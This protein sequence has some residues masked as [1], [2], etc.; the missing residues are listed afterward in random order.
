MAISIAEANRGTLISLIKN[1]DAVLGL[2]VLGIVIV[3][4]IP[5]PPFIMDILLSFSITFSIVIILISMYIL[6]PLEFSVF[7]SVLL[8]AT[9]MR[10]SI[11]VASTRLILLN[12]HEGTDAAG[13]VIKA[14][15]NFVIGGNYAVGMIIF[16]IL[17]VINFVVITKGAGRIAEVAA[18]FTLD[19]MP[20]K[21]MSIDADLNA[22]LIDD[23]EARRRRALIEQEAEFYGAMDGASKFV[24]G[25]AIAGIVITSINIVGGF[26]IGVLQHRMD[27]GAA[28][29]NYTLLT[30]GDGLV[31]Q[32][33][34]IIVS[35]SAGVI[36]TR[37]ASESN[38]G[39]EVT[40][41]I[42]IHPK[43]IGISGAI[44]FFFALIP[45]LPHIPFIIF[46]IITGIV[47]YLAYY[48]K[49][50][51]GTE[52]GW[53]TQ[54]P[55]VKESKK[56]A[57]SKGE[58]AK[59]VG[60]GVQP[61]DIMELH[62]GYG[63]IPLV[64]PEQK[65]ELVD[66]IRSVRNQFASEIGIII[67]PVHIRDSLQLA[68]NRY[69]I[70][71][72]G[73]EIAG[74]ELII[75]RHLALNPD[76]VD[77]GIPGVPTKEP[78]FGLPALWILPQDKERAELAGFTVVDPS[79]VIA[80]HLTE[81]I[82][83][84]GYELIGRQEMQSL[85]DSFS[86]RYPKVIEELIPN[87]LPLGV[88]VKVLQNL[89]KERVPI[90]DLLTILETLADYAPV[91]KD[92]EILTEYVRA[93]LS[94]TLTRQYQ[95]ENGLPVITLEPSLEEKISSTIRQTSQGTHMAIEPRVAQ[96]LISQMKGVLENAHRKGVYPVILTSYSV[97]GPLRKFLERFIP[98]IVVLSSNEISS[99][100]FIQPIDMVRYSDA[101]Q[102]V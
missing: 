11:N 52:I 94:R 71:I 86:K 65:G 38:L 24:R 73:V 23:S 39:A 99:S 21:Q 102:K 42:F 43:A 70:L 93:A 34:A 13:K 85:L 64:D 61:L 5:V 4:I 56:G 36:V 98:N 37:A 54:T 87:L 97:R 14:F 48:V 9:L 63:L 26:I 100:V 15:G 1:S 12:G 66:R 91:T 57:E 89:L 88:V 90:R 22:G 19:A 28:A 82:R 41:Q 83:T 74:G 7:P 17:V 45:G 47:A 58:S 67:P 50:T 84:H 62:L 69:S 29:Q 35:T 16:V 32:I 96:C 6:K 60:E 72:K 44:I 30:I 75:E 55:L 3:M 79:T 95:N 53:V 76:G 101:D 31:S 46:S 80:T 77:K 33:P 25:D 49:K 92:Q 8:V 18:R 51:M 27:I 2:L 20:G 59:E 81:V 68:P 78:S 10:L 40:K